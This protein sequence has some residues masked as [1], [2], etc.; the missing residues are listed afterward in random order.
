MPLYSETEG[1][2]WKAGFAIR[3]QIQADMLKA[4]LKKSSSSVKQHIKLNHVGEEGI[5]AT[6]FNEKQKV[7]NLQMIVWLA[8]II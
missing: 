8:Q 3:E 5:K 7:D 2:L 1:L 6:Q 4:K